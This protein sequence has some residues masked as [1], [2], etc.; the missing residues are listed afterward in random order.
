MEQKEKNV[1]FL[2]EK[3]NLI[4]PIKELNTFVTIPNEIIIK[5]YKETTRRF[6]N[7]GR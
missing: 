6:T 4:I 3:D 1:A 5:I 7:M 2:D